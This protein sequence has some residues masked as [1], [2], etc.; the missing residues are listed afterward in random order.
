MQKMKVAEIVEC[1]RNGTTCYSVRWGNSYN[2]RKLFKDKRKAIDF[3][4]EFNSKYAPRQCRT[5][6][7]MFEPIMP[8]QVNCRS[9]QCK[10]EIQRQRYRLQSIGCGDK[11]TET[12]LYTLVDFAEHRKLTV[13]EIANAMN[14]SVDAVSAKLVEIKANGLYDRIWNNLQDMRKVNYK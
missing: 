5:C 11:F 4:E 14:K 8:H 3:V 7:K 6:G 2:S 13:I 1:K 9:K 10:S 12:G